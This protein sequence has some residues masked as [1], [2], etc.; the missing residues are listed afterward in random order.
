MQ[1]GHWPISSIFSCS[2]RVVRVKLGGVRTGMCHFL[3]EAR[4]IVFPTCVCKVLSCL[5]HVQLFV[6][7]WTVA[8][9]APLSMG[10]SRQKYWSC[11]AL[12][13]GILPTQ[14][15]NMHLLRLLQWQAGS[16]SLVPT[17]KSLSYYH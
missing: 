13:Q 6:T 15:S 7:P 17:E 16:L 4:S 8:H 5:S 1:C 9:Q 2:A 14:G 3:I 10:F 11:C 12:F